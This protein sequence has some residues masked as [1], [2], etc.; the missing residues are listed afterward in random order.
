MIKSTLASKVA[1]LCMA[2]LLAF[3]VM[4]CSGTD[5]STAAAGTLQA[6]LLAVKK[7]TIETIEELSSSK[8]LGEEGMEIFTEDDLKRLMRA[9]FGN[10]SVQVKETYSDET[11]AVV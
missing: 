10:I 5:T 6:T 1:L 7:G 3:G 9:M 11:S 2:L 4:A 8:V